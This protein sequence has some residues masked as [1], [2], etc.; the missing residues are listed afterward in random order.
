MKI[1][2]ILFAL[3]MMIGCS[4]NAQFIPHR[5]DAFKALKVSSPNIVFVG[6]SITNIGHWHEQFN[7]NSLVV[8]RGVSGACSYQ[9]LENLESILIG[10]PAKMFIM[11]GT[12]DIGTKTG[13]PA[14]I[15]RNIEAMIERIRHESPS[16]EIYIISVFPSTYS[17]RTPEILSGVN[18]SL[19]VV[20]EKTDIPFIDLWDT[21]QGIL[22]NTLS[23]DYLHLTAPGYYL[24]SKAVQPYM[25]DEFTVTIPAETEAENWYP[26][27]GEFSL[28]VNNVSSLPYKS[29]DILM[30]GD[31][32]FNSGEWHE[33]LH[34]PNIKNRAVKHNYGGWPTTMWL[35]LMDCIFDVNKDLKEAPEQAFL[36]I[37]SQDI[38]NGKDEE[39]I[40][41]NYR[42]IVEKVLENMPTTTVRLVSLTPHR[43]ADHNNK[44]KTFNSFL[45]KYA[46]DLGLDFVDLF[47]PCSDADGNADPKYV[48]AS[49]F[50]T[51]HGYHIIA[52]T[53]APYIGNCTVEPKDEF[54]ARYEMINARQ[55]LG[56]VISCSY[57]LDG[58]STTGTYHAEALETLRNKRDDMYA[59]LNNPEANPQQILAM[60]QELGSLLILN[61]P[62]SGK[63]Y[64]IIPLRS[65]RILS[66]D[67]NNSLSGTPEDSVTR[68][69]DNTQWQFV[70]RPDNTWNII[71]R[72]DGLYLTP[73]ITLSSNEPA[74]GW[75]LGASAYRGRYIITSGENIQLYESAKGSFIN[76]GF[77]SPTSPGGFNNA[78]VGG[79]FILIEQPEAY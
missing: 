59:M 22:D 24:W 36:Y 35:N 21:F 7:D 37:G 14:T 30:I 27:A 9:A 78:D 32:L 56:D 3:L 17:P 47:T 65:N 34:N 31:E 55:A 74:Q 41:S 42:K 18:D 62:V 19:K 44:I 76:W 26:W 4:V 79:S 33:I 39:Y 63:Y 73:D 29:T 15:A 11:I 70:K 1:R 60:A 43:N 23:T 52:E 12:N 40:E 25:G 6:N 66:V 28:W 58:G 50:V 48:D 68:Q 8:N 49:S 72:K 53:L 64:Q 13:T 54:E 51:P 16:T 45:K 20:C 57:I 61:E 38:A 5:Y 46:A 71:N 10:K 75:D 67:E 2:C 77:D 69:C